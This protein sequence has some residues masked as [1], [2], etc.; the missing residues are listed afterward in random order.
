MTKSVLDRDQLDGFLREFYRVEEFDDYCYNGLQVEGRDS[1]HTVVI[2]VSLNREL[3]ATAVEHGADAVIVHHGFFGRDFFRVTGVRK[4]YI[5][6]LLSEGISLFGIHLPMDAHPELGHNACILKWLE[7]EDPEPLGPGF[8]AENK[9][10]LSLEQMLIRLNDHL[11]RPEGVPNMGG[12]AENRGFR[13]A[14]RYGFQILEN[15]PLIPRRIAVVSGGSASLYEA[16]VSRGAE[17][18]FCG[19]IKEQTPEFSKQTGTHFVH[20]GHYRSELPGVWALREA[21]ERRFDLNAI[22]VD[23]FS[24]PMM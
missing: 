18:F 5:S 24:A 13:V 15:G 12:S 17:A 6:T 11:P 19:E 2:G 16:A 22:F 7:G 20:L 10:G 4:R 3:L 1:I 14:E 21:L 8:L 9:A 23:V